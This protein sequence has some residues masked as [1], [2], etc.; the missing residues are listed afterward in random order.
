MA[1]AGV[2]P[3]LG[4][5]RTGTCQVGSPIRTTS[6]V[7]APQLVLQTRTRKVPKDRLHDGNALR[8]DHSGLVWSLLQGSYEG[9]EAN[10]PVRCG[11]VPGRWG[12]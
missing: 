12:R 11:P 5:Q 1:V 4:D 6:G 10:L 7:F 3:S 9:H 2:V 8:V